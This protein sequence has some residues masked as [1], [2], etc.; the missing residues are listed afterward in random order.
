VIS[1]NTRSSVFGPNRSTPIDLQASIESGYSKYI[2]EKAYTEQLDVIL[3]FNLGIT[4]RINK[5]KTSQE[6][7]LD[8]QNITG[9]AAR[10]GNYFD[11]EKGSV[12]YYNQ[13]PTLPVLSYLVNF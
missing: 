1:L 12:V 8:V 5:A 4:Y 11:S 10:V 2:E 7:K 13:M 9:N 3:T 6:I